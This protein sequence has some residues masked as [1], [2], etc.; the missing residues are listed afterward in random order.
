MKKSLDQI[1]AEVGAV[2]SDAQRLC[3]GLTE[4]QL[5]WRPAENKWSIAENL[6][7][8]NLTTQ[9]SMPAIRKCLDEARRRGLEGSGSFDLGV[10]GSWFVSYLEP[11]Y[12]MKSKAPKTIVPVL[13][14]PASEALPQ[15]LRC[16]DVFLK[17]VESAEGLDLGR[18][19]FV[20]PYFSFLRMKAIA[21]IASKTAHDR[22]H[23]WSANKIRE[24]LN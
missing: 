5:R 21:A 8:L 17:I 20:S 13:Q 12:K 14:G 18:A 11:P 22:R 16:N 2:N 4:E 23:L 7:H 15:Y 19:V 10:I 3:E 24:Q 1:R 9:T 6:A